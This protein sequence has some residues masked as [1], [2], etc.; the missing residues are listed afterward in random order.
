[1]TFEQNDNRGTKHSRSVRCVIQ[2]AV[3]HKNGPFSSFHSLD[4][5]FSK[6]KFK[7]SNSKL[8]GN[9]LL[10]NFC[11]HFFRTNA[12]TTL[13]FTF[14]SFKVQM[15]NFKGL[16]YFS[17]K[18]KCNT[19]LWYKKCIVSNMFHKWTLKIKLKALIRLN[20]TVSLSHRNYVISKLQKG[21]AK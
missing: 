14:G 21:T 9:L 20:V 16:T 4:N 11:L 15:V 6:L 1:M 3:R 12:Q 5:A 2:D 10:K 8:L 19:N 7:S 13:L 18:T 17:P